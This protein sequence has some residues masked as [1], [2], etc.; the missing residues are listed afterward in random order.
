MPVP[1]VV[2]AFWTSPVD[3]DSAD[4]PQVQST[5]LIPESVAYDVRKTREAFEESCRAFNTAATHATQTFRWGTIVFALLFAA[6][7][8]L[9][10]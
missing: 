2:N 4:L 7:I 3:P 10:R 8:A 6:K 5:Y 9:R 1:P